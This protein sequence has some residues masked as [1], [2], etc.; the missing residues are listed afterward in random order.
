MESIDTQ[1]I[2]EATWPSVVE[3]YERE[4]ISLEVK[5]AIKAIGDGYAFP[6]NLDRRP[7]APGGMAPESEQ[8][9]LARA[10]REALGVEETVENVRMIREDSLP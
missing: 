5:C 3:M 6:T 10:L 2:I 1:A 4:G 9:M 8:E 7:P